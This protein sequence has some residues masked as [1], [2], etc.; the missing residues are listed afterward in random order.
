MSDVVEQYLATGNATPAERGR[1][2]ADHWSPQ[3]TYLDPLVD[4]SGF[5]TRVPA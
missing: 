4:V 3:V 1:L 2:L 5:G